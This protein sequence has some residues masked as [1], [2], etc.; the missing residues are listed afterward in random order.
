MEPEPSTSVKKKRKKGGQG[1]REQR[2]A[3]YVAKQRL[4]GQVRAEE[5]GFDVQQ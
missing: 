3:N 4:L 5:T 2:T 1:A